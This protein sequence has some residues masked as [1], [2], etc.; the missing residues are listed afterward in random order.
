M[1]IE[2]LKFEKKRVKIALNV[3][4]GWTLTEERIEKIISY[5][6]PEEEK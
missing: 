1:T 4:R 5:L 2:K 6:F 3:Y